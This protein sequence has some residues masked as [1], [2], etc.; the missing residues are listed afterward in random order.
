MHKHTHLIAIMHKYHGFLINNTVF[1]IISHSIDIHITSIYSKYIILLSS[2]VSITGVTP[3][4]GSFT[5][6]FY[7]WQK[8]VTPLIT[9]SSFTES[10]Y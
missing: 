7:Q 9:G 10:F 2:D 4:G 6:S 1:F 5:K 8:G 3:L